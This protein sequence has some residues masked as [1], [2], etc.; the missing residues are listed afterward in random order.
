VRSALPGLTITQNGDVALL[1]ASYD[2]TENSLSQHPLTTTDDFASTTDS[3]LG[4]QSNT[5]TTSVFDP[6]LGDFYDLTSVGNEVFGT[7]SLAPRTKTTGPMRCIRTP[8]FSVTS[9][10]LRAPRASSSQM[11]AVVTWLCRIDP[12]RLLG[13][14]E[15]TIV[16]AGARHA[17]LARHLIARIGGTAPPAAITGSEHTAGLPSGP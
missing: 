4:T 12:L 3:M 14:F 7:F 13:R 17:Y 2:P 15:S 16:D 6:Y 9:G 10:E 8:S 1:Y 5:T 11:R